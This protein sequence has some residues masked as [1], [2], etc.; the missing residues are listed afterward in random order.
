MWVGSPG[1]SC[2]FAVFDGGKPH[3]MGAGARGVRKIEYLSSVN[4][5]RSD[6]NQ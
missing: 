2:A 6:R 3:A 5:E 4:H 1:I